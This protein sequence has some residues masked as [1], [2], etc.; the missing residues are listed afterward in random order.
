MTVRLKLSPWKENIGV[1]NVPMIKM[2][3]GEEKQVKI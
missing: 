1:N 3:A 2:N